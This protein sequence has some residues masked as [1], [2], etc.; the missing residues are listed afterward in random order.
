MKPHS[1]DFTESIQTAEEASRDGIRAAWIS[2]AG[3]SVTAIG[4]VVIFAISGSVALLADTVHNAGH[5]ITTIPLVIAF[6]LGR[7][8]PTKRYPYGYRR[9]EDLSGLF[10]SLIIAVTAGI[11][12]WEAVDALINQRELENTEWVFAAGI[13]GALGNELVALYRI[14]VG[15]RIGSAALVA[16]GYHARAD[17]ITSLAVVVGVILI[18]LGF[19]EADGLIGIAIAIA[20]LAIL[21]KTSAQILHRLMDGADDDLIDHLADVARSVPAVRSVDTVRARWTGHRIEADLCVSIDS[22]VTVEAGHQ[23]A[24]DVH[25]AILH[26]VPHV[27][28]VMVHV[29]PAGHGVSIEQMHST[30]A[31]HANAE[32]R[33]PY[34]RPE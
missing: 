33:A 32:L 10:I 29:N 22:T 5:A 12:V 8:A 1:H 11:I 31:H 4:Q 34:L 17:G 15:R 7:R 16:E 20:I 14:R 23:V 6:R 27:Q 9:A 28:T 25:H 19:E 21:F 2:L 3:M 30:V 18:W 13:V 24:Q 26:R